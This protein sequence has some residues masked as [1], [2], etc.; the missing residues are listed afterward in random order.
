[1]SFVRAQYYE[2]FEEIPESV[3]LFYLAKFDNQKSKTIRISMH[4]QNQKWLVM[5]FNIKQ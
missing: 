2:A 4:Q 5:G 3:S 1:M